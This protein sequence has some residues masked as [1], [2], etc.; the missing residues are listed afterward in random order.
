MQP[1]ERFFRKE[2][3][4]EKRDHWNRTSE[5]D[6][7]AS[8]V[9]RRTIGNFSTERHGI[10]RQRTLARRL[11]WVF[12]QP[13]KKMPKARGK[14][15][16]GSLKP[17]GPFLKHNSSITQQQTG[18]QARRAVSVDGDGKC[19][20][21][22]RRRSTACGRPLRAIRGGREMMKTGTIW[23]GHLA[24]ARLLPLDTTLREEVVILGLLLLC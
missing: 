22:V 2:G 7:R 23:A 5:P 19:A 10:P 11:Q 13:E 17:H 9:S 1:W 12:D 21:H 18:E 4:F 6:T 24:P 20:A 14:V 15:A 3:S 16:A 8:R